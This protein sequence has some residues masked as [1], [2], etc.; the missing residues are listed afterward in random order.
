M[1]KLTAEENLL[2]K[3]AIGRLMRILSR[4]TQ[5]GDAKQYAMCR[6]V[7]MEL[8]GDED[9]DDDIPPLPG[10]NF[11]RANTGVSE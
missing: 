9:R 6:R 7:V 3:C 1:K 5:P 4:P 10:W 8:A 2:M 11:G